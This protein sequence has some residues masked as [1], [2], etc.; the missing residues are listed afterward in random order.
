MASVAAV[1]GAAAALR[2]VLSRGGGSRHTTVV[3]RRDDTRAVGSELAGSGRRAVGGAR[4]DDAREASGRRRAG[5][6]ATTRG[7]RPAGDGRRA[8]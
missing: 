4:C 8:R 3:G 6:A 2:S 7:R 5:H 1:E